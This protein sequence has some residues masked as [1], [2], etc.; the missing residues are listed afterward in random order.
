MPTP[1]SRVTSSSNSP[2][3]TNPAAVCCF[4]LKSGRSS[5]RAARVA[6]FRFMVGSPVWG[7]LT[8]RRKPVFSA[9]SGAGRLRRLGQPFPRLHQGE[10]QEVEALPLLGVARA[11]VVR[12]EADAPERIQGARLH[13]HAGAGGQ[14]EGA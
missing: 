7:S 13:Q 12:G 9:G 6:A 5:A 1:P 8:R 14:E 11:H 10:A 3:T 4:V 2:L